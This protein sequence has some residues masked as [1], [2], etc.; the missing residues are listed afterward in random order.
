MVSKIV[1]S[2]ST[3]ISSVERVSPVLCGSSFNPDPPKEV[4]SL[5][6]SSVSDHWRSL[7]LLQRSD[8]VCDSAPVQGVAHSISLLGVSSQD[9]VSS[10][11]A[12][13]SCSQSSPACS[14]ATS[15]G[16][17]SVDSQLDIPVSVESPSSFC[18]TTSP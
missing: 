9:T 6:V 3:H 11:W 12:S 10:Q 17:T 4:S 5:D 16:I 14:S 8:S 7:F 2:R 18:S 1:S 15:L 13:S